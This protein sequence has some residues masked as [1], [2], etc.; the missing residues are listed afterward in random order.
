MCSTT[1]RSGSR[2]QTVKAFDSVAPDHVHPFDWT[3]LPAAHEE[4]GIH[5]DERTAGTRWSG[6][7]MDYG[8]AVE[9]LLHQARRARGDGAARSAAI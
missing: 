2:I 5:I 6:E 8:L 3:Q 1:V 4:R 9:V 7:S